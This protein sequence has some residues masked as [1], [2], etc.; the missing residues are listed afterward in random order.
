MHGVYPS[1]VRGTDANNADARAF[2]LNQHKGPACSKAE[3]RFAMAART[4]GC[5][6]VSS[7][8]RFVVDEQR[9]FRRI[10]TFSHYSIR[11]YLPYK[12]QKR[13]RELGNSSACD[14]TSRA[15]ITSAR[16]FILPVL[17]AKLSVAKAKRVVRV[18]VERARARNKTVA[19]YGVFVQRERA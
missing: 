18:I 13:R 10:S 12:R 19:R 1:A 3:R 9:I 8:R 11:P 15:R 4:R 7:D 17:P 16:R 5:G 2:P 14:F 6:R